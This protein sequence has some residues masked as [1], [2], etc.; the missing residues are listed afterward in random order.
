MNTTNHKYKLSAGEITVPADSF[1]QR[2]DMN[3]QPSPIGITIGGAPNHWL[4]TAPLSKRDMKSNTT[5]LGANPKSH[6]ILRFDEYTNEN[7]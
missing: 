5:P 3:I 4:N 6:T 1:N 2:T 7:K